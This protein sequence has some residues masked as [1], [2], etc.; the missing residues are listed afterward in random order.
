MV[1]S[2]GKTINISGLIS[3]KSPISEK[4]R[5][6]WKFENSYGILNWNE[7]DEQM[8]VI[9]RNAIKGNQLL[10]AILVLNLMLLFLQIFSFRS[11]CG[12][13]MQLCESSFHSCFLTICLFQEKKKQEKN[14]KI[15]IWHFQIQI[16]KKRYSLGRDW[17]TGAP[18]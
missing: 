11:I 5:N 7:F 12:R 2:L 4:F 6:P 9:L 15:K 14:T 17:G 8:E 16:I 13:P 1:I 18:W 10:S 3:A